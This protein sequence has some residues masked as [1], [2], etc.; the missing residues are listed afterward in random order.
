MRQKTLVHLFGVYAPK[1]F[2]TPF[3]KNRY[4]K[5]VVFTERCLFYR[6]I[7][8]PKQRMKGIIRKICDLHKKAT[9]FFVRNRGPPSEI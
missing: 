6:L 1:F 7:S 2:S 9:A 5:K 4:Q 3:C 8:T